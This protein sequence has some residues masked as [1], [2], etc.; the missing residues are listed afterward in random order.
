MEDAEWMDENLAVSRRTCVLE[1]AR[2]WSN[3]AE[4]LGIDDG[5]KAEL[6]AQLL[7]DITRAGNVETDD[8]V[9]TIQQ[10][11]GTK[12]IVHVDRDP[13]RGMLVDPE[14]YKAR[15][16]HTLRE[17]R[18][19]YE[20]HDKME[21]EEALRKRRSLVEKHLPPRIWKKN[22]FKRNLGCLPCYALT[23][24]GK[25]FDK[26]SKRFACQKQHQHARELVS[27]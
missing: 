14:L 6:E 23:P 2:S 18:D 17:D 19:T 11:M 25:C 16:V 20:V 26:K 7:A 5:R 24:T 3:A 12:E 15:V 22:N 13:K 4:Q 21:V 9:T 10:R 1:V 27:Y 8:L